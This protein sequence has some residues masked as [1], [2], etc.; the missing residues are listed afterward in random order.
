[1]M[2]YNEHPSGTATA[3]AGFKTGQRVRIKGTDIEGV[4]RGKSIA[5]DL[6]NVEHPDGFSKGDY[7]LPEEHIEPVIEPITVTFDPVEGDEFRVPTWFGEYNFKAVR[8]GGE[9]YFVTGWTRPDGSEKGIRGKNIY[10]TEARKLAFAILT[11]TDG[12]HV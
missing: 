1:M 2:G 11:I 6:C 8:V 9:R 10:F 5:T 4:Y 7:Y 12:P 3:R